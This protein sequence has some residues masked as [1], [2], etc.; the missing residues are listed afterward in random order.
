MESTRVSFLLLLVAA[1]I[2][3]GANSHS[4]NGLRTALQK[5]GGRPIPPYPTGAATLAVHEF[6]L[7]LSADGGRPIPPYPT[8]AATLTVHEFNLKLSADG[9]RPI[10]PYPTGGVTP[11]N[12]PGL[13]SSLRADGG[14]PIP[15][16]PAI[17]RAGVVATTA[18]A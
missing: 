13:A 4:C 5:D 15:P 6:N 7:K 18:T 3:L 8:G 16:Y 14:R 1:A 2:S 9:G 10:P 12:V 11:M 17:Q